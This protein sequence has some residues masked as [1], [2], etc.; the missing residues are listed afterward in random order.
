MDLKRKQKFAQQRREVCQ[1]ERRVGK[2]GL[3]GEQEPFS[4][5]GL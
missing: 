4:G 1:A 3:P 2:H 5:A